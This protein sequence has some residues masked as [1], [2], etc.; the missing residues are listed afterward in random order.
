M[1]SHDNSLPRPPGPRRGRF[2]FS[3]RTL[4]ILTTAVAGACAM[5]FAAPPR[6]VAMTSAF[7]EVAFAAALTVAVVYG[8]GYARTF[9]I[10]GLF[11]AS[12]QMLSGSAILSGASTYDWIFLKA[13]D[14]DE[15]S[16]LAHSTAVAFGMIVAVG[17]TAMGVRWMCEA[18]QRE[19]QPAGGPDEA[20]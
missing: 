17:L 10:G 4:F 15:A 9:A 8:R 14:P 2:Q 13:V 5:L 3:L 12:L 19:R 1:T 16:R 20:T 6:V 18:R 7:L 11:P